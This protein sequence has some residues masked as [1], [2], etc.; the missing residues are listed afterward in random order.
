MGRH[1]TELSAHGAGRP[2]PLSGRP[3]GLGGSAASLAHKKKKKKKSGMK[4][5]LDPTTT[6]K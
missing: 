2:H 5:R 1:S 6:S 3:L 4:W